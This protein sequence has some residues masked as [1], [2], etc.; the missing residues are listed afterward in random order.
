MI[1]I[2]LIQN[3]NDAD[4]ICLSKLYNEKGLILTRFKRNGG[5]FTYKEIID[6]FKE[7]ISLY[8]D[9]MYDNYTSKIYLNIG[10]A[11]VELNKN[12][13]AINYFNYSIKGHKSCENLFN[14]GRCFLR[15]SAFA[16]AQKD[17]LEAKKIND[18]SSMKNYKID[19]DILGFLAIIKNHNHKFYSY[20]ISDLSYN[21][22]DTVLSLVCDNI[23]HNYKKSFGITARYEIDDIN[24]KRVFRVFLDKEG[25]PYDD[26]SLFSNYY[27]N[28]LLDKG[29]VN[30]FM[31]TKTN[32]TTLDVLDLEKDLAKGINY[33]KTSIKDLPLLNDNKSQHINVFIDALDVNFEGNYQKGFVNKLSVVV[34]KNKYT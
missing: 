21:D 3:Q 27:A 16:F 10:D 22:L 18:N 29:L 19:Y 5:S 8:G 34:N 2:S 25:V 11:L 13:E 28:L 1:A 17:F 14:R 4:K 6:C 12:Y 23:S 30:K 20:A 33:D 32:L 24:G 31:I 7:S 26:L 9:E 15:M